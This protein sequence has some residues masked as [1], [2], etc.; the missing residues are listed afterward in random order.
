MEWKGQIPLKIKKTSLLI[1]GLIKSKLL[2]IYRFNK[3]RD[4]YSFKSVLHYAHGLARSYPIKI[5]AVHV[6]PA[7]NAQ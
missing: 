1:H 2:E 3:W 5:Y 7:A 6:A 4:M